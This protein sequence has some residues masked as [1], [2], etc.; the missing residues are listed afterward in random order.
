MRILFVTLLVFVVVLSANAGAHGTRTIFFVDVNRDQTILE[1]DAGLIAEGVQRAK[2][3]DSIAALTLDGR[4]IFSCHLDKKLNSLEAK[5]EKNVALNSLRQFYINQIKSPQQTETVDIA[6]A[7]ARGIGRFN[8]SADEAKRYVLVFL[9]SGLQKT[10]KADF[11][12]GYPSDSW[13]SHQ[14]S[15]FSRVP[16]NQTGKKLEVMFVYQAQDFSSIFHMQRIERFYAILLDSRN[17]ELTGFSEDHQTI[18]QLVRNGSKIQR[19]IPKPENDGGKLVIYR[20]DGSGQ[21]HV[22]EEVQDELDEV[23][24]QASNVSARP[25]YSDLAGS[26]L[27]LN[28][29]NG[30]ASL[31]ISIVGPQ[32]SPVTDLQAED[33]R[34]YEK[35]DDQ[36]VFIDSDNIEVD[37]NKPL[38]IIMLRDVS[39]SMSDFDLEESRKAMST[40]LDMMALRDLASMVNFSKNASTVK[41]FTDDKQAVKK[42]IKV[43]WGLFR[44]GTNLYDALIYCIEQLEKQQ[45]EYLRAVIAFTDGSDTGSMHSATEVYEA[46]N[47][48]S[49]PL[50]LIGVGA[51][52]TG[53][54][55]SLAK[56]TGGMYYSASDTSG[57]QRIY[58]Q[59]SGVLG[60]SVF[61]SYPTSAESGKVELELGVSNSQIATA[62]TKVRK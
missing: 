46:A 50:F 62:K 43:P 2:S 59:L 25:V 53:I 9:S 32:G 44:N 10:K 57:L 42:S 37:S 13:I 48:A 49:I 5:R 52:E 16:R 14:A 35:S 51:V 31:W 56:S 45:G 11:A 8:A 23:E 21:S 1:Q 24:V 38:A 3:G 27:S 54:L 12:N 41:K 6:G 47:Q 4:T 33:F 22:E 61:L 34:I 7:L 26:I 30:K 28:I 17:I 40:F 19:Q 18:S 29:E 55:N 20:V 36:R 58:E 15:P 60:N 39:P